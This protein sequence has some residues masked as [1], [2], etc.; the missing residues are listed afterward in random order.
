MTRD[1]TETDAFNLAQ[2]IFG[3]NIK[4]ACLC[5]VFKFGEVYGGYSQH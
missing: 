4:Y 1:N 5:S 2:P 3:G